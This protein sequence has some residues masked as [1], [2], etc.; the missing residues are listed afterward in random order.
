MK[1]RRGDTETRRRGDD[2][3]PSISAS[4]CPRVSVSVSLSL[5]GEYLLYEMTYE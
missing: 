2:V 3:T 1:K 5:R 4:S